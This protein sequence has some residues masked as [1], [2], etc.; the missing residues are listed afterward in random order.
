MMAGQANHPLALSRA[1]QKEHKLYYASLNQA[2]LDL[3]STVKALDPLMHHAMQ[4]T[5]RMKALTTFHKKAFA[6]SDVAET[7]EPLVG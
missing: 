7:S 6:E 5:T 2:A 1:I 3:T 4:K